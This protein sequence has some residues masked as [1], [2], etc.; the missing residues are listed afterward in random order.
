MNIEYFF[1][2]PV[3]FSKIDRTII[4]NTLEKT[5]RLIGVE[6]LKESYTTYH[7]SHRNFLGIIEDAALLHQISTHS[8]DF[9]AYLGYR[10]DDLII[11]NWLNI[12]PKY[13][14]HDIHQHYGSIVSGVLYLETSE[15]C[16][17]LVF[18]DPIKERQQARSHFK[19]YE[20][21][22]D[23]HYESTINCKPIV[24][25]LIMFES[26]VSHSVD[27]NM[28]DKTRISIAFNIR[29]K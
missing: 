24:G 17:D 4:E 28:S 21:N 7:D 25:N 8:N 6:N 29:K 23:G 16:G 9:L 19:K 10:S 2:F 20:T 11:E 5:K 12:N 1:S 14:S 15:K 26:W 18:Y 13:S 27:V 22:D 3:V